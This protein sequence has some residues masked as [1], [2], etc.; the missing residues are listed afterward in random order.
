MLT[1]VLIVAPQPEQSIDVGQLKHLGEVSP[2]LAGL[3][4]SRVPGH[5]AL[6]PAGDAAQ[7]KLETASSPIAFSLV[8][9]SGLQSSAS[10]QQQ[11]TPTH[12]GSV[13]AGRGRSAPGKLHAQKTVETSEQKERKPNRSSVSST[14]VAS[15][16]GGRKTAG[17]SHPLVTASKSAGG[18]GSGQGGARPAHE[19]RGE[20]GSTPPNSGPLQQ[21]GKPMSL[22]DRAEN[23][24]PCGAAVSGLGPEEAR[25]Q[26]QAQQRLQKEQWQ[27]KHGLDR[28][29]HSEGDI[30]TG[31]GG[32]GDEFHVGATGM[33]DENGLIS[34]GEVKPCCS[35]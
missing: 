18:P 20:R 11:Q 6:T 4:A 17:Q 12:G 15:V 32:G 27:R 31:G 14:P 3:R 13:P 22:E 5:Q 16:P 8:E 10:E 2:S 1:Q 33:E 23:K 30:S 21:G 26:R 34:D 24:E 29:R 7:V 19:L 35:I 9:K 28:K 25:K